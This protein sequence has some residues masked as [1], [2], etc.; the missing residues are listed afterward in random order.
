MARQ[1]RLVLNNGVYH[2]TS[3]IA[4]QS[5]LLSDPKLK[6]DIVA[7]IYGIADFSGVEVLS[8]CIMNNHFHLLLHVPPVPERYWTSPDV[9]PS[10][11]A[12]S[13]RPPESRA[14]RWTPDLSETLSPIT[15]AG[16]Q[17][18]EEAV[19]RSVAD[20]VPLVIPPRPKTGFMLSDM[21]MLSRLKRLE[22][23]HSPK[24][25]LATEKRW[26]LLRQNDL[27]HEVDS[28]K[29]AL[30]RR[31]YNISQFIKTLKQRIS[32]QFNL[33]TGHQG[34]LWDG[35]FYSGLV[36]NEQK[37]LSCV[38]AYIDWN[39][40]RAKLVDHS[41]R[42]AWCSF[43]CA[44]GS[45]RH[46]EH[47]RKGY[48]RIFSCTW[49]EAQARME[50]IFSDKLPA[51]YDPK[52]DRLTCASS[53]GSKRI[54]LRMS[55]LIKVKLHEFSRGGFISRYPSFAKRVLAKLPKRFPAPSANAL[56][57]F[58]L[59]DWSEPDSACTA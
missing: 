4:N 27:G 40:V 47:A 33:R 17:P 59:T 18:S 34:R 20:G 41:I 55:Q 37:A 53:D 54:R 16:D 45:G 19:V 9:A 26:S 46:A 44:S 28:E 36:E 12:F 42:W 48:E 2:V 31:M 57:F 11:A 56:K 49:N 38:A 10:S 5:L 52:T 29:D 43:A 22:D 7:W 51:N 50:R 14:P 24:S 3:R 58:A 30:C 35:R 32:Q 8:W 1:N 39:P 6:D 13:M 25:V 23:G 21:E 15:P